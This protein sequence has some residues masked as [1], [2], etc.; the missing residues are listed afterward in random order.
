MNVIAPPTTDTW[1]GPVLLSSEDLL[2]CHGF[3]D[4]DLLRHHAEWRSH[5]LGLDGEHPYVDQ[6]EL[7]DEVLRRTLVPRL[8]HRQRQLVRFDR[9]Q[10]IGNPVRIELDEGE[11]VEHV[12]IFAEEE[13]AASAADLYPRLRPCDYQMID[14]LTR[15]GLPYRAG[16][17]LFTDAE[18]DVVSLAAENVDSLNTVGVG[19]ADALAS[20]SRTIISESLKLATLACA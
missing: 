18:P 14:A 5:Q 9:R 3:D 1:P 19:A 7:L 20:R 10:R 4:G 6:R 11:H 17:H 2:A 13:I 8:P 12:A 15:K 16:I